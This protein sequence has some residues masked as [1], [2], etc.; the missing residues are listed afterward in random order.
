MKS[1]KLFVESQRGDERLFESIFDDLYERGCYSRSFP[2]SELKESQYRWFK[3]FKKILETKEFTTIV[4]LLNEAENNNVTRE[5]FSK[6]TGYDMARKSSQ[7]VEQVVR[8]Y[9]NIELN[10]KT[11]LMEWK[12]YVNMTPEEVEKESSNKQRAN[13]FLS[14]LRNLTDKCI[15]NVTDDEIMYMAKHLRLL[16]QV[17]DSKL[18]I[19]NVNGEPTKKLNFLRMLGCDPDII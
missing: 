17:K 9:C 14:Q 15:E 18:P 1:F 11:I 5:W 7:F 6:L 2:K 4:Y 16:K 10:K 3:I 12:R 13:Y 19:R 8:E